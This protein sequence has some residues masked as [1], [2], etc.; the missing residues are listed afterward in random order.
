MA[1][2]APERRDTRSPAL[3]ARDGV[4]PTRET[5][6]VQRARQLAMTAAAPVSPSHE[7]NRLGLTNEMTV[8][9]VAAIGVFLWVH[10]AELRKP[11]A[12]VEA[13][14]PASVQTVLAMGG[15]GARCQMQGISWYFGMAAKPTDCDLD[16]MLAP[17]RGKEGLLGKLAESMAGQTKGLWALPNGSFRSIG[18]PNVRLREV[19]NAR[20]FQTETYSVGDRGLHSVTEQPREGDTVSLPR[21]LGFTDTAA[22][23][24]GAASSAERDAALVDFFKSRKLFG[25]VIHRFFGDPGLQ[26]A[27]ARY[28]GPEHQA[29]IALLRERLAAPGFASALS[30]LERAEIEL[31]AANPLD[32][33]SCTARRGSTQAPG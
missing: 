24:V 8:G 3:R 13:L 28:A 5:A 33:V 26:V 12:F 17:H 1:L 2:I 10:G 23:R 22:R 19:Q 18:P 29:A 30:P 20:C 6:F 4:G 15:E 31:L 25:E 7:F 14:D 16:G 9:A 21:Y 11:D 27:A 32:F